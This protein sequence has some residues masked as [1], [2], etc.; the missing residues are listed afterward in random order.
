[1]NDN[2]IQALITLLDDQDNQIFSQIETELLN[3]GK[4]AIPHLMEA[5]SSSMDA[6]LQGRIEDII[7]K[8]QFDDNL[9]QLRVWKK[10]AERDLL[11]GIFIMARFQYPDL[12]RNKIT[13]QIARIADDIKE[14]LNEEMSTVEKVQAI[15]YVMFN[16]FT[17]RGNTE[18]FHAPQNSFINTVLES[19]KGNPLLLSIIY[20]L[21]AQKNNIPVYGINLPQ[22]FVLGVL[23]SMVLQEDIE[24]VS[25]LFYINPFN[26]GDIFGVEELSIFLDKVNLPK[27]E[28]FY[29]PC[30]N[31]EILRRLA[32]NLHHSYEK[33]G[34]PEK[35][36]EIS[37][38]LSILD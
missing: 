32:R 36:Y 19:H 29:H 10:S 24:N 12:E 15:N 13:M 23:P 34:Y 16:K 6:V 22:H 37:T 9:E 25:V 11:D 20:S 33:L 31:L 4:S 26:K 1:M 8:I 18:N 14:H 30:N 3:F 27:H 7:H 35:S 38:I 28:M 5:W 2:K 17:F 21:V